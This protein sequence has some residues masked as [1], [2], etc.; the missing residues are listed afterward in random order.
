MAGASQGMSG[1]ISQTEPKIHR[2]CGGMN[3]M[4]LA[5]ARHHSTTLKSV[6]YVYVNDGPLLAICLVMNWQ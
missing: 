5:E 2:D 1:V 6:P 4:R 3:T